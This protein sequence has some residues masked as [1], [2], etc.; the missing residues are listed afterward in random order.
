MERGIYQ[1]K[2]EIIYQEIKGDIID[3]KYKPNERI[4][5]SEVARE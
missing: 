5:I 4:V 2:N 1:T 3:G